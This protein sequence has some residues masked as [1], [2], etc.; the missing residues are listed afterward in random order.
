[1]DIRKRYTIIITATMLILLALTFGCVENTG[2][3]ELKSNEILQICYE[4]AKCTMGL[5]DCP[6]FSYIFKI[7]MNDNIERNREL[8]GLY[9]MEQCILEYEKYY[10]KEERSLTEYLNNRIQKLSY[11]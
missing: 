5:E 3:S 8:A 2:N 6:L 11:N 7:E 1:M 9:A 10:K 4:S